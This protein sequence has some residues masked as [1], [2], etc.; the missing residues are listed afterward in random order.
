MAKNGAAEQVQRR[1]ECRDGRCRRE[2][3]HHEGD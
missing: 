1:N 3:D 2:H